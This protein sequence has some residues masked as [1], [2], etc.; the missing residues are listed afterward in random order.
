MQSFL[1]KH[2]AKINGVIAY[3]F[4][5]ICLSCPVTRWRGFSA[6]NISSTRI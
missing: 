5:A 3:C 1:D 6:R 2:A 4:V